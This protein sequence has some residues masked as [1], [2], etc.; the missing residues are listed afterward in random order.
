MYEKDSELGEGKQGSLADKVQ[1]LLKKEST[2]NRG[3]VV[4]AGYN[5]LV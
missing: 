4:Q 1:E 2:E 5:T 3:L